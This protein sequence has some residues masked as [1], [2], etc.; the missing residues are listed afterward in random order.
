MR[1]K[2]IIVSVALLAFLGIFMLICLFGIA[3]TFQQAT[4]PGSVNNPP[5]IAPGP[6]A[7]A[8]APTTGPVHVESD[9]SGAAVILDGLLVGTAPQELNPAAGPHSLRFEKEGFDPFVTAFTRPA[10]G[11]PL[12]VSLRPIQYAELTVNSDPDGAELLIDGEFRGRTPL[13][14]AHILPGPHEMIVR[15]ANYS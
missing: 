12:K 6:V 13:T 1:P 15:K 14:V 2:V 9:P 4:E 7:P 5:P 3:Y 10:G 8:A 11:A